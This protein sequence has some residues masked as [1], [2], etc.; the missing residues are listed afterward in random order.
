VT[1]I[2]PTLGQPGVV[3]L[4]PLTPENVTSE[5]VSWLNDPEVVRYTEVSDKQ[6][7]E[8]ARA[9]VAG[10]VAQEN[11][12]LWRILADDDVHVGNIRMSNIKLNHMRAE[13]ALLI[14]NRSYWGRGIGTSAIDI[15]SRFGFE[16]IGLH[17][18]TAGIMVPNVG[19]RIAFERAG[20]H[21][22]AKFVDHARLD[23]QYCDTMMMAK[24]N[25]ADIDE[26]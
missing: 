2:V 13:I 24:F 25:P 19:S 1:L 11:S 8:S 16:E 7:D 5:Y 17:K 15:V 26:R 20:Y 10:V 22:E 3:S 9:Y 23:G 18:L 12:A 6:S 21:C 4:G 14:G